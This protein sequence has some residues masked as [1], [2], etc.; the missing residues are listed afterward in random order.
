[1]DWNE[2]KSD[3]SWLKQYLKL[4]QIP[5]KPADSAGFLASPFETRSAALR[6][7]KR[8]LVYI[9]IMMYSLLLIAMLG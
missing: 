4:G 2:G 1:M 3:V 8:I 5:I 6:L 7:R 9:I